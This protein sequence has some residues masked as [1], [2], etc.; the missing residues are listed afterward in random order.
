MLKERGKIFEKT[1]IALIS[2]QIGMKEISVF[3]TNKFIFDITWHG[4]YIYT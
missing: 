3:F 4:V 1:P 2:C